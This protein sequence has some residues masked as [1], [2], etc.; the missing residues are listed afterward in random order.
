MEEYRL[1]PGVSETPEPWQGYAVVL[2]L[3]HQPYRGHQ[4]I[5]SY[6]Y[7]GLYSN[8]DLSLT[9]LHLPASYR[10]EGDDRFLSVQFSRSFLHRIAAATSEQDPENLD[11]SFQFHVRDPQLMQFLLLLR[12][13]LHQGESKSS[14]VYVSSLA[15]LIALHLIRNYSAFSNRRQAIDGKHHFAD[16]KFSQVATYIESHL[17]RPLKLADVAKV[18]GLSPHHFGRLFKQSTGFSPRQYII[19]QRVQK[20]RQLLLN[21][22]L[23]LADISIEC[24]FHS[25]SHFGKSFKDLMGLTPGHY[26]Q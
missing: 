10:A 14:H 25:Q 24:G 8:G 4:A 7:S 17:D 12:T 2:C 20:A 21:S 22:E 16:R 19:R 26:R 15:N 13:E 11:L 18:A 5:G 3:S 23:S 9:P 6:R 1:S